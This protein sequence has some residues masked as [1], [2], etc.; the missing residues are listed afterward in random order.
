MSATLAAALMLAAIATAGDAPPL[1]EHVHARAAVP[2]EA[3]KIG[4]VRLIERGSTTVVQTVLATRVITR[5]VAEIRLKDERNWPL[6]SDGH[7]DSKRFVEALEQGAATLRKELPPADARSIDDPERRVRLLIEFRAD[8]SSTEV[9]I[10]E[11][12]SRD[13]STPY[14]PTVSRVLATLSLSRG[15]VL[16]NMRLILADSFRVSEAD[17]GRLGPLGPLAPP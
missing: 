9:V 17:L 3:R 12:E 4:E 5:A 10:A 13:A 6:D 14:E 2:D 8:S 15:Y 7:A 16:E 11:F 1:A